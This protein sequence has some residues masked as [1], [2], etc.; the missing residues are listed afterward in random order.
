MK[1]T[2]YEVNSSEYAHE[3]PFPRFLKEK[4]EVTKHEHHL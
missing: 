1:V 2:P 3:E 4:E